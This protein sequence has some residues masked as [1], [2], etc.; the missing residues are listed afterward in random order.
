MQFRRLLLPALVLVACGLAGR[1]FSQVHYHD[2]KNPWGQ[3][4][5]SGPDAEVPG[6]FYNLG[7][8]GLRVQ[9]IAE[10]PR[11]LLVRY[12][13]P[14][15]P[16]AGHVQVGDLLIG[17]GGQPFKGEHR[18]GYGEKVFGAAGP[19]SEFAQVL[20]ACQSEAGGGRLPIS[21]RR[22]GVKQEVVL[23]VGTKYGVYASSY[24]DRCPKSEKIRAELL[25]YLCR[26]QKQNGSFGNPVHDTFAPLALL[27]SGNPAHQQAVR[28]N[29]EFHAGVTRAKRLQLA[30]W[31][32]AS[33]AIVMSEFYLATGEAW[34][35][36]ELRRVHARLLHGQYL[37]RAQINPKAKESHPHTFPKGLMD[38]HGGWGHNPGFEGYGPISM[39][40]AQGALAFS[41]LDRCGIET[42]RARL[43][44]ALNFLKRGTGKNGYVWY[45]DR[46]GGRPDA[47]A[48][49]GR[50]GAAAI[51]NFLRPDGEPAARARALAHARVI[52]QH[53]QSFPDTHGSP[54]MGMAYTALG[55]HV[56]PE[57]FRKLMDANRW[58]FTL[59]QCQD[60]SFYYQPN[61]DNA[62]YGSDSRMT[63]SAVVAF[64]FA[65]PQRSLVVTGRKLGQVPPPSAGLPAKQPLKVFILAGQSN[66][67]GHG[68]IDADPKR[69]GGKGSLEH[70]AKD[71]ATAAKYKPL[72]DQA[73]KWAVRDDVWIHFL[74][75]KGKLTVGYGAGPDCIGP[76]LGF[77]QVVGN[78]YEEPV[79]LIKLAWGG[80]SLAQDFR[81]PSA[82]GKVGPFYQEIVTRTKAV[83]ADLKTQFPELAD[84]PRE[85]AGF[86]WHQG[87]ND[88]INPAF[89]AEYGSNLR[90]LIRDLRRDLGAP[91]LPFV[92]AETGMGGASEKNRR[93]LALM[94]AQAA[95]AADPEFQGNVAFVG[96]RAFW[97]D[98]ADSPSDQGY[99]WNNSAETYYLIGEAMGRAMTKLASGKPAK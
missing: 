83:L 44:A 97:R 55:A 3:R 57:S 30:N 33:A 90:H 7:I 16:A 76:E 31:S 96:T 34:V 77:G 13:F 61:R 79:L 2:D 10:E 50:T 91:R 80:K 18:N 92:I 6:W 11:A 41:L 93:A 67:V 95:V 14:N 48:D 82:G 98:Q 24:P 65:I 29:V 62:G 26:H 74:D 15:S 46:L 40:T 27:A 38:A 54:A 20:E 43:D 37:D 84:R 59:A 42:D 28:R 53:P 86:G 60:G 70:L 35:L 58:W 5:E 36:P 88:R 9:L 22:G 1:T 12:V 63:A 87:W 32:Y 19:I 69:N 17:A 51:A 72:L 39:L 23:Q 89:V 94:E 25:D 75:R 66:M 73:G 81:P 21:L 64:I 45:N 4:A 52:G 68:F 99:H 78:A 8:T 85:L 47:W 56:D 49:M 71:A